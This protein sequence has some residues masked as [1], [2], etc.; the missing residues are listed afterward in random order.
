MKELMVFVFTFILIYMLY[1]LFTIRKELNKIERKRKG[2]VKKRRKK[3]DEA[4]LPVEI[5]YLVLR[6]KL[7]LSKITYWK[8]LQL[9]GVV[10]SFDL[11]LVVTVVSLV[12]GTGL[13]LLLGFVLLIPV[14]LLSYHF[15][16]LHYKKKGMVIDV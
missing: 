10:T 6:Y 12:T 15:I 16:G 9:M 13:Q 1:Y 11:A 8:L 5:Q 14:L 3:V 7:D 4:K 2:K